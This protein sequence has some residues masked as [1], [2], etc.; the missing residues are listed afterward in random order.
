MNTLP[1]KSF[2]ISFHHLKKMI[3]FLLKQMLALSHF[4]WTIRQR[5]SRDYFQFLKQN[6]QFSHVFYF[7]NT[8]RFLFTTY[9]LFLRRVP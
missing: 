6:L 8:C 3:I 1:V 9:L 4:C 7:N 2:E 5:L